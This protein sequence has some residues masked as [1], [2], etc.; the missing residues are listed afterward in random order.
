MRVSSGIKTV[1]DIEIEFPETLREALGALKGE[2]NRGRILSGGTDLMVQWAS[3]VLPVPDHAIS[4][5]QIPELRKIEEEDNAIVIGAAVTHAELRTSALVQRHLPALAAA[6]GTV[7]GAQIQARGTIGGN[8]ANASPAGDL[9]PALIITDGVVVVA[10]T[11][12]QREIPLTEFFLDYRKIDLRPDELIV[13]FILP[14]VPKGGR[15]FFWKIG[16]RAAQAI[17]NV[18]GACRIVLER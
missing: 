13:R 1:E 11:E 12:G 14:K 16:P 8:V 15:E 17:S 6:A 7:G 9:P 2:S 4:V 5:F 10:S 3:G 18:M